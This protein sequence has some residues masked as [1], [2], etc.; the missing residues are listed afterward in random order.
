[1]RTLPMVA[2]ARRLSPLR[3]YPSRGVVGGLVLHGATIR[4]GY[5][6]FERCCRSNGARRCHRL[7][8]CEKTPYRGTLE[9]EAPCVPA[10]AGAV[11]EV[12]LVAHGSPRKCGAW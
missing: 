2:P 3:M 1:M 6:A 12:A 11:D 7:V 10:E 8:T 4:L 9:A 5:G